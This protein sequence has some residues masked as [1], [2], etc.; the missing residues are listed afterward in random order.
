MTIDVPLLNVLVAERTSPSWSRVYEALRVFNL[1]NTDSAA[2]RQET[3]LVLLNGAFERA[4]DTSGKEA[5][6]A[7]RFAAAFKPGK[8]VAPTSCQRFTKSIDAQK[9]F[10]T[11]AQLRDVWV[12]DFFRFRNDLAHG[13]LDPTYP[14]LWSLREHLLLASFALPLLLKSLLRD[15][16]KYALTEQDQL[17][18]DS[19]EELACAE[20][21]VPNPKGS[22]PWNRV[23]A[24][25]ERRQSIAKFIK[26]YRAAMRG[27]G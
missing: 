19:F 23:I 16:G 6:V 14:A 13:K 15:D 24:R 11:S 12:R 5:D 2:I 8:D 1:A 3:E 18:I 25:T 7:A 17:H 22:F 21:F 26:E 27:E 9:R 20:H 4:L 10:K